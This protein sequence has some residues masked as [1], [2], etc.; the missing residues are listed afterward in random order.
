VNFENYT[1]RRAASS[2]PPRPG[3]WAT[4]HQQFTPSS[5]PPRS[6]AKKAGDS[7]VTVE[8]LLLALAMEKDAETAK[9]LRGPASTPQ[10]LNAAIEQ[11]RKGRT[12]DSASAENAV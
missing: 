6:L 4:G 12:A 1:D 3:R 10:A 9:I 11:I 2:S 8:R 7:F 5:T